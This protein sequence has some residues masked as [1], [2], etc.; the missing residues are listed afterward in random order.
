M[1]SQALHREDRSEPRHDVMWRT[2]CRILGVTTPLTIVNISPGG[3][4]A[5]APDGLNVGDRLALDLPEWGQVTAEVRW[6]LG[7]R[8]GCHLDQ[9]IAPRVFEMM[10]LQLRRG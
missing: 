7:G 8:I 5:R 6:S 2:Q 9:A 1:A 10:L 4:M 3:F